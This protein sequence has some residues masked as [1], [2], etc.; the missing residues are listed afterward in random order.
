VVG[1][2]GV[3]LAAV[4]LHR[5]WRMRQEVAQ[6]DYIDVFLK[7]RHD[8]IELYELRIGGVRRLKITRRRLGGAG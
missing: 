5:R 8:G 3:S 2:H 6:R 4:W 1:V 7:D